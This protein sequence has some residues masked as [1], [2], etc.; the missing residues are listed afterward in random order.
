M[1]K[2]SLNEKNDR[3]KLSKLGES[4]QKKIFRLESMHSVQCDEARQI[5][6]VL[7]QHSLPGSFVIFQLRRV[8]KRIQKAIFNVSEKNKNIWT[9]AIR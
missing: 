5:M 3:E 4:L 9:I 6:K 8:K 7:R 1:I 2:R